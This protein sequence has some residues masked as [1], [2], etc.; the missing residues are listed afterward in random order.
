MKLIT[1]CKLILPFALSILIL[2]VVRCKKMDSYQISA[3]NITITNNF[4]KL[5]NSA[6]QLIKRINSALQSKNRE[7]E[8]VIDFAKKNGYPIWDKTLATIKNASTTESF[9]PSNMGNLTQDT[10]VCIP[11]VKQGNQRVAGFIEA[12]L[13]PG[14][15]IDFRYRLTQDY[16]LLNYNVSSTSSVTAE[17]YA[18]LIMHFEKMIFG[19][20]EFKISDYNLFRQQAADT[21]TL[22]VDISDSASGQSLSQN[23]VTTIYQ[24]TNS[25]VYVSWSCNNNFNIVPG[26]GIF[27]SYNNCYIIGIEWDD[28]ET[29][30][31]GPEGVPTTGGGSGGIPY[32]YLCNPAGNFQTN[33]VVQPGNLPDCPPANEDPGW[34]P[35]PMDDPAPPVPC[36]PFIQSLNQNAS[37]IYY[38]KYLNSTPIKTQPYETGFA[39]TFPDNY[40]FKQGSY[41]DASITWNNLNNIGAIMH[42][43][44]SGLAG[45]FTPDDIVLMA[46]IYI[47][48][49]AQD[50]NNLFFALTTPT[51]NPIIMKVK[52]PLAFRAFALSI[53][54]DGVGG[55]DDIKMEQFEHDYADK[56][57]SPNQE[58]NM[59]AFLNMLKEKNADNAIGLYQSDKNCINWNPASLTALGSLQVAP[60]Q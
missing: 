24:C 38:L 11:F 53:V 35:L 2:S 55:W 44:Y 23:N 26:C 18:S 15:S 52:D 27:F 34:D 57:R 28:G 40:Q 47:G 5:S 4:F 22:F 16:K 42:C 21:T 12:K 49:Y 33:Q 51:G 3:D 60:C 9:L 37:F 6:D 29:T 50:P 39:V 32:Y 13:S 30:G 56:F 31:G 8:F 10:I 25:Q 14:D 59:V 46:Q 17:N 41:N 7:N 54:G 43:H 45:I 20:N 58:T 36:D 1:F 19:Y 48:N